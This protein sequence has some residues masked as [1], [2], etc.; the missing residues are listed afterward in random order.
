MR[1]NNVSPRDALRRVASE[2]AGRANSMMAEGRRRDDV[3]SWVGDVKA[4]WNEAVHD[5]LCA[6][7][8]E[9]RDRSQ[10]PELERASPKQ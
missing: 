6:A 5:H 9:S 4:A 1:T 2:V 3:A 8:A 10:N 7:E